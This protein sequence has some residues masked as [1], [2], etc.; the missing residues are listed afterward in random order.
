MEIDLE[1]RIRHVVLSGFGI[2]D[3]SLFAGV[4]RSVLET[5]RPFYTSAAF[6]QGDRVLAKGTIPDSLLILT[7]GE[8]SLATVVNKS[9]IGIT[10]RLGKGTIFGLQELISGTAFIYDLTAMSTCRVDLLGRPGFELLLCSS[11]LSRGRLILYLSRCRQE[12]CRLMRLL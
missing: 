6:L 10:C 12:M 8:V 1:N 5:V 2:A 3:Q 7:E 4:T 9:G 11:G